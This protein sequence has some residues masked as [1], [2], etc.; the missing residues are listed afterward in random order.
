MI[1]VHPSPLYHF[2]LASVQN[3]SG[4]LSPAHDTGRSEGRRGYYVSW[5]C[6]FASVPAHIRY[7]RT[8]NSTT[9]SS[10]SAVG[11]P[12]CPDESCFSCWLPL[13]SSAKQSRRFPCHRMVPQ[14]QNIILNVSADKLFHFLFFARAFHPIHRIIKDS[15]SFSQSY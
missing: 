8:A 10:P 2:A 14:K 6:C 11:Y 12:A 5:W 4:E 7:A 3:S 13:R 1:E 15:V 9:S